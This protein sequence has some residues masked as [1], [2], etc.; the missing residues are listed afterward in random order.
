MPELPSVGPDQCRAP[1]LAGSACQGPAGHPGLHGSNFPLV[2]RWTDDEAEQ[3]VRAAEPQERPQEAASGP[4]TVFRGTVHT[5]GRTTFRGVVTLLDGWVHVEL[6]DAQA[7]QRDASSVLLPV[8]E[9]GA[10][11]VAREQADRP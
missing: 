8:H 4:L 11:D 5:V 7:F 3:A 6:L 9:V 10:I 2:E 1:S